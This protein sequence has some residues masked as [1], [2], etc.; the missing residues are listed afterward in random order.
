MED[1]TLELGDEVSVPQKRLFSFLIRPKITPIPQEHERVA[2]PYNDANIISKLYFLWLMPLLRVGYGRT[3]TTK[4]VFTLTD[5]LKVENLVDRYLQVFNQKKQ[6]YQ[7]IHLDNKLA[8]RNETRKNSSKSIQQDLQDFKLS[9]F[10]MVIILLHTFK[11]ELIR[12]QIL[13]CIALTGMA[14]TPLLTKEIIKFVQMKTWQ[15]HDAIGK[16]IGYSIGLVFLTLFCSLLIN[17]V[18]FQGTFLGIQV[19]S[20]FINQ[21]LEKSVKLNPESKHKFPISKI[22]SLMSTDLNRIQVAVFLQPILLGVIIPVIVS[23]A[24][25]IINIGV[26]AVIGLGVFFLILG[27]LG[28]AVKH[29]FAQREIV[30]G[31]TDRRVNIIKEIINN[32]R[33]IKYYSWESAYLKSMIDARFKETGIIMKIQRIRNVVTAVALSVTGIISM[34]SFLVLYGLEGSTRTPASIFSSISSFEILS[35]FMVFIPMVLAA[36]ADLLQG[37]DRI[38]EFLSAPEIENYEGYHLNENPDYNFENSIEVSNANFEWEIFED[39]DKAEEESK[40]KL[41]KT[42]LEKKNKKFFQFSRKKSTV[43]SS[44]DVNSS[45]EK[46]SAIEDNSTVGNTKSFR[47]QNINLKVKKGEF[48]V[49]TG[50]IGSGK[51]SLLNALA[52]FMECKGGVININGSLLNCGAPWV[53]NATIRENIT[54]GKEFDSKFYDAIVYACSLQNDLKVL[55]AGDLTEV[56]E[57]GIT[58]SGGQKARINLARAVY[59]NKDIILLDDVLSAVDARVGKHIIEHCLLN[60]LQEKTRILATHQLSLIG[61]ADRIIFLKGDGTIE[62]GV[63]KELIL[64]NPEFRSLMTHIEQSEKEKEE[65]EENEKEGDISNSDTDL[66]EV[67]ELDITDVDQG[68][69]DSRRTSLRRRS[70][71][72]T[73]RSDDEAYY[74]DIY[75]DKDLSKAAITEK[76]E[77]AV[78]QIGK[79]VYYNYIKFGSGKITWVGFLLIFGIVLAL[80]TFAE[81]FTNTWLSFWISRKFYGKSNGFYI[82]IYVMLNISWVIFLTMSFI[83]LITMTV[84]ASKN[85]HLAA[86]NRVLHAPMSYIDITPI[87]RILNRFTADTN[88]LDDEISEQARVLFTS[89]AKVIG[90]FILCIIYIPWI[91]VAVPPIM[92]CLVFMA[93]Y[94]QASNREIKRLEATQR[95]CVYS[96]FNEVLSGS[97]T[98]KAYQQDERFFTKNSGLI[99]SMNEASYLVYACQRWIDLLLDLFAAIF[100]LLVCL[101]C[102]NSVFKL[103]PASVGLLVSYSIALSQILSFVIRT[104]TEFENNM[105]SAERVIYYALKLPQEAPYTIESTQPSNEWP[106]NGE[107][108]FDKVN[109]AYR[110]GLPLVL[111]DVSFKVKSSEKIG[112]CGRTG[113]GKSSILTA[114]YRIAELQLG[115][116]FIDNVDISKLGLQALRSH[117]SIIPQDPVLFSG[118]IKKNLDPFGENS[119]DKLWDALRRAHLITAEEIESEKLLHKSDDESIILNKFHLEQTVEDEGSNFSLGERQLI[120]FARAL[121]RDTKILV[122]DEATSSVDYDTDSKIQITISTEFKDCTILCIAHRLK[123]ILKYDKILTLD[124]GKV[125]EFDTP[126]N[127]YHKPDG[128]F[129]QM[130]EKSNITVDE[131]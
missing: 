97:N 13:A 39:I 25:L 126:I 60:L 32:I 8:L 55:P 20:I 75:K 118:T 43:D 48:I 46:I 22:T 115:T 41:Q 98:I 71:K 11:Y 114:L 83:V 76:E 77:V 113:A 78:N 27:I 17:H 93:N 44:S 10:N 123:T 67:V 47:L 31:F 89:I 4:D 87:G 90:V 82:G 74:H 116:I 50:M 53:Q 70:T 104:Y 127:L 56:G 130:C 3:L 81:L 1:R 52:G 36:T 96:N 38:G 19:K 2:F 12:V 79:D 18:F 122:L 65:E 58:L 103:N 110:P 80:A 68:K 100:V 117:L 54:F 73:M 24:I 64:N 45:Q 66:F 111:K 85:L 112:I 124:N 59:A 109:M 129:R 61:S 42:K 33:T 106:T 86:I 84:T 119:D 92:F 120:A 28:I 128:I 30:T 108:I 21:L 105:N 63:M 131:F 37:L 35:N 9:K 95:S 14:V 102:V 72:N 15:G 101:L 88:S 6:L 69:T 51:S 121:V 125:A 99:N 16:G 34:I 57:K 49:V 26:S 62:V 94:Y 7:Q 5:D 91:A 29:L 40:K 107:V 23:V